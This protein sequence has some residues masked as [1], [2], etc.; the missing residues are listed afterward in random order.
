MMKAAQTTRK[1]ALIVVVALCP[2]QPLQAAPDKA[3]Q[4]YEDATKA[5]KAGDYAK[6]L[7]RHEWYHAN[8]LRID[9]AYRGV[10]LSFALSAW[11]ELGA[12]YPPALASLKKIR[13]DGTEALIRGKGTPDLFQDVASINEELSEPAGTVPLFMQ[14]ATK[15][16]NFAKRCFSFAKTPLFEAKEYAV[17]LRYTG[18]PKAALQRTIKEHLESVASYKKEGGPMLENHLGYEL[19]WLARATDELAT[20]VAAQGNATL[21]AELKAMALKAQPDVKLSPM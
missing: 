17:Y 21:A 11:I 10:R 6:A 15:R 18:D 2:S 19:R 16:P 14:L 12:K 1:L 13:D 20:A 5:A 4:A 3:E 9:P 8:A 7:E